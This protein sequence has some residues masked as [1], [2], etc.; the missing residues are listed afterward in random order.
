[1]KLTKWLSFLFIT[2]LL[3]S[4]YPEKERGIED[5]DIVGTK[6]DSDINFKDYKTYRLHDSLIIIYDTTKDE[7]DYPIESA[8]IILDNIKTNLLAYGW[9]E[10]PVADTPDVYLEAATWNSTVVK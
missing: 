2:S 7:P 5:Y 8:N 9:I 1:M 6:F 10:A 3:A 4:C